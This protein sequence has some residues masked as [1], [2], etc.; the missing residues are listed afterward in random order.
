M[1]RPQTKNCVYFLTP[2]TVVGFNCSPDAREPVDDD[3]VE[4]E[5]EEEEGE[6]GLQEAVEG[7][8]HPTQPEQTHQLKIMGGWYDTFQY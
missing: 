5:H 8:R 2:T 1:V 4:G 7:P 3:A 6:G